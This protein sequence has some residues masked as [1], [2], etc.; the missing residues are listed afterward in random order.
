MADGP[1][2][3]GKAPL[4]QHASYKLSEIPA[5]LEA[6]LAALERWRLSPI[7]MSR[8]GVAVTAVTSQKQREN[9][10]RLL[11]WLVHKK[12]LA[13]PTLNAFGSVQ[14]GAAVQLYINFLVDEKQRK[15]SS[16]AVYLSSY[17]AAARFVH[18]QR[19]SKGGPAVSTKP[20][21]DLKSMHLQVLQLSRQQAAFDESLEDACTLDWSDVQRARCRAEKALADLREGANLAQRQQRTRDVALMMYLTHQPPDR[22]GVCR[23]LKLGGTLKR[24]PAGG[25]VLDLSEP[26]DHKTIAAFGPSLTTVPDAISK[27]LKAHLALSAVP[28][29]SGYVFS[30]PDNPFEPLQPVQWTRLVQAMFKRYSGVAL[31]P[32]D[33]RSS[34]V[35]WLKT[36][37]HDDATL[38]AAAQAMRHSSKTQ[39][40]AAYNK[41]KSDRLVQQAVDAAAA[42]ASKFTAG[43]A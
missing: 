2:G 22:V 41:G 30:A 13:R 16:I 15:Y 1:I 28:E 10:V 7:N 27:A 29:S 5:E 17:I 9:V 23:L 3:G 43:E 20:I 34:H 6:E 32:K 24:T 38:R 21:D 26:G 33:L 11:G 18:A 40:S 35:T 42:F 36:G 37:E 14:I 19:S 8:K 12:K 4:P 25:F 39:D 31:A